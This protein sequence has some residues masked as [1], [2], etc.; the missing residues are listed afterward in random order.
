M[1]PS[2]D[3]YLALI[4]YAC[5]AVVASVGA[6]S[7]VT[8]Q[9]SINIANFTAATN[10]RFAN[11]SSLITTVAGFDLSGVGRTLTGAPWSGT[12]QSKGGFWGTLIDENIFVS[13]EHYHASNGTLLHFY[14]DNDPSTTP[15]TRTISGGQQIGTSDLWIGHLE[16]ALPS[17]IK[18]YDWNQT[19]VNH[20]NF[21]STLFGDFVYMNGVTPTTGT[22]YDNRLQNQAVGENRIDHLLLGQDLDP[23]SP[24]SVGDVV[25]MV[26]N[27]AGDFAFSGEFD[28]ETYEADVNLGDSGSPLFTL[29][30]AGTDLLVSGTAWFSAT[31]FD[32]DPHPVNETLRD[33]SGYTFTG[34]YQSEIQTYI[35][36]NLTMTVPEPSSAL[37]MVLAM[38]F[39]CGVRRR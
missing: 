9:A 24:G 17:S 2:Q 28:P 19:S 36:A 6:C 3:F 33:I 39:L 15:I 21:G 26:E 38:F 7:A 5:A 18:K 11:D 12:P 27:I 32:I 31:S 20:G 35:G 29:N 34:N 13:A 8:L 1:N 22:A 14:P 30:G 16:F 37:L 10:D 23:G 4:R 25:T